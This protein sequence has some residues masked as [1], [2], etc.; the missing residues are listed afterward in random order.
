MILAYA[1][2]EEGIELRA[3]MDSYTLFFFFTIKLAVNEEDGR[4]PKQRSTQRY[5]AL[6]HGEEEH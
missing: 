6:L 2:T 5:R 1:H 3:H 4:V